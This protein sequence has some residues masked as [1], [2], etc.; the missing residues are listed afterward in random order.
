MPSDLGG[1]CFCVSQRPHVA[2]AVDY[3]GA[4]VGQEAGEHL[5]NLPYQ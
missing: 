3:D 5:G 4:R 1:N 2:G